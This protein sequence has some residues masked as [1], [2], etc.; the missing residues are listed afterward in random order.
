MSLPHTQSAIVFIGRYVV[1]TPNNDTIDS[2]AFLMA[3]VV[4]TA[5]YYGFFSCSYTA[6]DFTSQIIPS[7][8][9][10]TEERRSWEIHNKKKWRYSNA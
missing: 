2:Q 1:T 9:H 8:C 4:I 5:Y 3:Y 10:N 6:D 7:S